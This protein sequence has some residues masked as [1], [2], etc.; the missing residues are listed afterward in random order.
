[1]IIMMVI[2]NLGKIV[3]W[4]PVQCELANRDEREVS[5]G[6]DLGQVEG[7]ELPVFSLFKGHHLNIHGPG[8]EVPVGDRV[9]K[10][11]NSV[12]RILLGHFIS[13]MPVKSLDALV[14][15]PVELAVD[16]LIVI[17]HHLECVRTVSIH[18]SV[19]IG[20]SAVRKQ[21]GDLVSGHGHE[22]DEVPEHVG[23]LEVGNRVPLL[24]VDEVGEEYGVPDEED[25]GVVA[26]DVPVP[27]LGVELHS[28][29]TR[30]PGSVSRSTLSTNS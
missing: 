25:G 18:E 17:V 30:V 26:H 20:G 28:K 27:L 11:P 16:R 5:V 4:I 24:G 2:V 21:E 7:V 19:A 3:S 23:V 6:P 1:M 12:I 8:G 22:G 9:V 10:I 29:S 15:L 13:L 14:S